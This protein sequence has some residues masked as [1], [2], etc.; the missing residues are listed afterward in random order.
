MKAIA[1]IVTNSQYAGKNSK[2]SNYSNYS[3]DNSLCITI[4]SSLYQ[5]R[6]SR[7]EVEF[8]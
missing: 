2:K 8:I 3:K 7:N 1:D 4:L 6:P 5:P